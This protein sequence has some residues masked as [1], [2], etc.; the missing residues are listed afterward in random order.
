[1]SC[2]LESRK[3]S[4]GGSNVWIDR[5]WRRNYRAETTCS[6][7]CAAIGCS[8]VIRALCISAGRMSVRRRV[9]KDGDM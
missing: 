2:C 9:V 1:M 5:R 3:K 6:T 4:V 7:G 8:N